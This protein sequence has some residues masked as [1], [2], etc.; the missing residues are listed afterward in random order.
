[1]SLH[2]CRRFGDDLILVQITQW[3]DVTGGRSFIAPAGFFT[4]EL[5]QCNRCIFCVLACFVIKIRSEAT[6]A[7]G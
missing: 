6:F 5:C 4:S 1:M 3:N 7:R 2:E